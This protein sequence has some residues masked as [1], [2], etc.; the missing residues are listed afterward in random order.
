MQATHHSVATKVQES[1]SI[2]DSSWDA[3]PWRDFPSN[4]IGHYMGHKPAHFPRAEVKVAYDSRS[5]YLLFRVEDRY[6]RSVALSH[7]DD[8][9]KDSCVEFFFTPGSDL[10]KGY[11]NIS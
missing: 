4:L 3:P 9:Y 8:V 10:S 5:I 11:F 6:V 7:Q 1:F 2:E